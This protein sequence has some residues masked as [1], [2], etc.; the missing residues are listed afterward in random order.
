MIRLHGPTHGPDYWRELLALT[1]AEI[2][3]EPNYTPA[4]LS[5]VRRPAL[6]IQGAADPV[7]A[8]ARHAQFMAEHI[9]YA[10]VW[11]PKSIHH[12]VHDEIPAERLSVV[13]S[14]LERRGDPLN[15]ALYHLKREAYADD[16]EWVFNLRAAPSGAVGVVTLSGETLTQAQLDAA[17]AAV[18]AAAG[19]AARV[20]GSTVRVLV[21]PETPW[22]LVNRGVCD[23]NEKPSIYAGRLSQGLMG[24]A[25]RILETNGEWSRVRMERDGYMGWAQAGALFVCDKSTAEAY[26]ANCTHRVQAELLPCWEARQSAGNLAETCGKLPFGCLALVDESDGEFVCLRLPDGRGWWARREG[27]LARADWPLPDSAG[28]ETVLKLARRFAG[29]PYLWG[30]RSPFGYDC[31]GLTGMVWEFLGVSL[32]RDADQQR[33]VGQPIEGALQPGDLLFFVRETPADIETRLDGV[34]HVGVSLGGDRFLHASGTV[35]GVT[36]NSLDPQHNDFRTDLQARYLDAR[37]Y[38]AERG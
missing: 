33:Q 20:D 1:V 29:A 35:W 2:L 17:I 26:R 31:S 32:P 10:E 4:T 28:I 23:V 30:G 9:P 15:D 3:A 7:N 6:I 22:A 24:E 38:T 34:S 13:Q 8:P 37:R 14:F 11:V 16:R 19:G 18:S 21:T 25:F 36:V 12:T 5:K 27:L